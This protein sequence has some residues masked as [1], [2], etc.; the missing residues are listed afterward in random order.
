MYVK[1]L[2]IINYYCSV[3]CHIHFTDQLSSMEGNCEYLEDL[4]SST[5][6]TKKSD[7]PISRSRDPAL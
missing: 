5:R 2:V 1:P 6:S 4:T 3:K 7:L